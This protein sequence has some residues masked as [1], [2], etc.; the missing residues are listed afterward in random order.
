VSAIEGESALT[1]RVQR[2]RTGALTGGYRGPRGSKRVR[3]IRSRSD[4]ENQ[5]EKDKRLRVTL[6]GGSGRE[7]RVREAVSRGPGHSI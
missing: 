3:T 2:Q 5:T 1:E 7:A 6:T 4:G